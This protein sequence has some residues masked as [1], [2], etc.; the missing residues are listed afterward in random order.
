MSSTAQLAKP[1]EHEL[2]DLYHTSAC[3]LWTFERAWST[4]GY[5][6]LPGVTA[7]HVEACKRAWTLQVNQWNKTNNQERGTTLPVLHD[8]DSDENA[9]KLATL[10][11][12]ALC[13]L[14][15]SLVCFQDDPLF[16]A[17]FQTLGRK[18]RRAINILWFYDNETTVPL[19][20]VHTLEELVIFPVH[21]AAWMHYNM[22]RYQKACYR[23]TVILLRR[24]NDL[25]DSD[26]HQ[27]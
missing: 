14:P 15:T 20:D 21:P 18:E 11:Y 12:C 8:G 19:S 24:A 17:A 6:E 16:T 2:K 4:S 26:D 3:Q 10:G 5:G 1:V 25:D 9:D 27:C 22:H 13:K 23:Y 7:R